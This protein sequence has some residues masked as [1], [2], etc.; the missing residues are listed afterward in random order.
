MGEKYDKIFSKYQIKVEDKTSKS[1]QLY[2]SLMMFPRLYMDSIAH[3]GSVSMISGAINGN[4]SQYALDEIYRNHEYCFK[5]N[6]G[7]YP[8][9]A[10]K[11]FLLI[12][13]KKMYIFR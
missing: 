12:K 10:M 2:E 5:Y 3:A 13:D 7:I 6:N 1:P 9:L 4:I 8:S 11:A